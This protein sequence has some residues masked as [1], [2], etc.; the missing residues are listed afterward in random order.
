[1]DATLQALA[2]VPGVD[3]ARGLESIGGRVAVY[4][5]LLQTFI[6]GHGQDGTEMRRL[7]LAGDAAAAAALAHRLRG[8][9]LTLGLVEV[10]AVSWEL[11]SALGADLDAQQADGT[12][13]TAALPLARHVEEVLH[14][15]LPLLARALEA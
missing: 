9:A 5:R 15:L 13:A 1:M 12:T 3:A 2:A 14:T 7:L 8:A 10:E 11:E 4:R 6:K